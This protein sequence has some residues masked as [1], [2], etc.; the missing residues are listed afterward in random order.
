MLLY[1]HY[2]Q[3]LGVTVELFTRT[4]IGKTFKII[5][6]HV[7]RITDVELLGVCFPS[8]PNNV[9]ASSSKIMQ[10]TTLTSV[11]EATEFLRK[12]RQKTS[13]TS[14]RHIPEDLKPQ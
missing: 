14:R 4:S 12:V 2:H 7:V 9:V 5:K 10:F 8:S 11:D 13:V 1:R 6:L 3:L